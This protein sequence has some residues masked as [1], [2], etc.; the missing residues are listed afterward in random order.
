MTFDIIDLIIVINFHDVR[1]RD[2]DL[3]SFA[4]AKTFGIFFQKYLKNSHYPYCTFVSLRYSLS[5]KFFDG[6]RRW[7]IVVCGCKVNS[8]KCLIARHY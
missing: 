4:E 6:V 7:Q 8:A 3:A 2:G 5:F 1:W